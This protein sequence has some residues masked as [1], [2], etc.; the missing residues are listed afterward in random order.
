MVSIIIP[1]YNVEKYLRQCVD[2]VLC[3]T[4]FDLEIILVD[5]GSPDGCGPICDEY[6]EK[7]TRIKVIHKENGGLSDARNAGLEIAKGEYIYF[8]DSDD[9]IKKDAIKRLVSRIEEEKA[10]L[11]YFDAETIV[12]D[13]EDKDYYEDFIRKHTYKTAD[14][15]SVIASHIMHNEYYSVVWALFLRADFIR[16]NRLKFLKGIIHEDELFT[17]IAFIRAKNAAQLK[18]ALYVRRLRA[19]S[20]MSGNHSAKS[21][22]GLTECVAG[23]I[24]ELDNFPKGSTGKKVLWRFI[25]N[26]ANAVIDLYL[27]LNKSQRAE[28]EDHMKRL[29]VLMKKVGYCGKKKLEIKL[30]HYNAFRFYRKTLYPVKNKLM[31]KTEE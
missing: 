26:M 9:Y 18:E 11:I 3:Q 23:Y 17:P 1:I 12:E 19:D 14:G 27:L 5:D 22:A 31:C 4:Y 30:K 8:L 13:F 2:S 25:Y 7:D 10:D 24:S 6:A 29:D 28:T 21:I 20:I 16:E 15:A